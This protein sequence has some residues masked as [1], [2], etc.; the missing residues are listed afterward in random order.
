MGDLRA[1]P[2]GVETALCRCCGHRRG[3]FC[4]ER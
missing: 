1:A 3:H 2:I 4:L